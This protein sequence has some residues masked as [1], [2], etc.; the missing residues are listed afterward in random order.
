MFR[1]LADLGSMV[2]NLD[3]IERW[4]CWLIVDGCGQSVMIAKGPVARQVISTNVTPVLRADRDG[5]IV[6][7]LHRMKRRIVSRG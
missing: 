7:R 3:W 5:V 1:F 2:I 4:L 6:L